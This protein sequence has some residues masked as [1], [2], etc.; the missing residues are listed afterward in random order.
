MKIS[1]NIIFKSAAINDAL[2]LKDAQ[3]DATGK[4]IFGGFESKLQTNPMP[5]H[6]DKLWDTT[7]M[8]LRVCVMNWTRNRI[9][10]VDKDSSP[11]LGRLRTKVHEI[12][13]RCRRPLVLSNALARSSVMFH[14]EDICH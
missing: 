14:S 11:I 10:M 4:L 13:G 2:P 7:L 8:P 6:L 1:L 12:L 5:F 3:Y 9:L